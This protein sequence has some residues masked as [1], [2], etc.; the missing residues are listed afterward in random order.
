VFA[1]ELAKRGL[2]SKMDQAYAA[3]LAELPSVQAKSA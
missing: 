3:E 2:N 1:Q